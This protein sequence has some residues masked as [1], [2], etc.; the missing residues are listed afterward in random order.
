MIE[1]SH[2]SAAV[3]SAISVPPMSMIHPDLRPVV[4]T[5]VSTLRSVPPLN[6]ASLAERRLGFIVRKAPAADIPYERRVIPG[7]KGNPDLAVLL[8]NSKPGSH[9]PAIVHM[10]GGGFIRGSAFEQIGDA[11]DI[12]RALDCVIVSV[13]YRLAPETTFSGSVEDNYA[14]LKWMYQNTGP[15]GLD[16][17]R[18]AVLGESAGGGHAALL[19][20]TARDRGEVPVCFQCLIYP[21]LDDRTGSSKKVPPHVGTLVWTAADNRFGWGAFLGAALGAARTP[22]NGVPARV[23][24]VN[25]LPPA[26]IAVGG[27]DLFLEENVEF[28]MRLSRAG[29]PCE[30]HLVDGAFHGFDLFDNG[31]PLFDWFANTRNDALRRAFGIAR[32]S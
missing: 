28:A 21:M 16:G 26:F 8:V 30:L 22:A 31:L 24:S 23:R 3:V 7:P 15:L 5:L 1:K 11:Q 25:G 2:S 29:I 13:E 32:L 18:I 10:H 9:R 12:A 20:I 17:D 14:A 6:S 19:A 27:L 4:P